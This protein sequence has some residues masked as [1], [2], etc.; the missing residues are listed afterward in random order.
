MEI[1]I[2]II[3]LILVGILGFLLI[4]RKNK[5]VE[6]RDK[7]NLAVSG[8]QVM[9]IEF[10]GSSH[11]QDI[12]N[13]FNELIDK[14]SFTSGQKSNSDKISES[15]VT[16]NEQLKYAEKSLSEI[17]AITEIGKEITS[18][19]NIEEI[20][21]VVYRNLSSTFEIDELE[22][23]RVFSDTEEIYSVSSNKRF[24]KI[25]EIK[26]ECILQWSLKN[27]KDIFLIN[28]SS[29][30]E[31]Y[32]FNPVST[33]KNNLPN[34]IICVPLLINNKPVGAIAIY[35]QNSNA[36]ADYHLNV[37]KMLASYLSVAIDNSNV[38]ELLNENKRIIEIEKEKSESLLLNILPEEVAI[39]LKEN[40]FAVAKQ[41][42]EVTVIFTDFV[43]FTKI[44]E[45]LSA[46][47]L[48]GAINEYFTEF[49]RIIVKHGLEK[50]KTIGDAYMAVC[51]LPAGNNDH[52]LKVVQ[53]AIE[54][55]EFVVEKKRNG[56]LFDI[57]IG[58]NSGG[59]IAGI[60]G[61]KKYAYDIWGDTV[62]VA[63][64]MESNGE[65]GKINLSGSTYELIKD[66]YNCEYRGKINAKNKGDIDM[67]YLGLS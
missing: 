61:V 11:L 14:N 42:D 37:M 47:E 13:N 29:D 23:Y 15:Q 36:F 51:G 10:S 25:S 21:Q 52:A 2:I 38:Y 3:L 43:G 9:K 6:L 48:V 17:S 55:L 57:R 32:F 44:S 33:Y 28:A 54:I 1:I 8:G 4:G 50:I 53:A 26:K 27:K 18:S 41:Y 58:L 40:G 59:V 65:M 66:N 39:E 20:V 7:I 5:V 31:Q 22:L 16:A 62:N 35:H 67:Y 19:L 12:S 34:S 24:D 46:K 45:H 60:I 63:A 64:R 49:D 56:G 30:F